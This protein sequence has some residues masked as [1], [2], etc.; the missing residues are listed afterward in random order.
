MGHRGSPWVTVGHR[1]SVWPKIYVKWIVKVNLHVLAYHKC[2]VEHFV[3]LLQRSVCSE[4]HQTA[5]NLKLQRIYTYTLQGQRI[6]HDSG[7]TCNAEGIIMY[8]SNSASGR[9]RFHSLQQDKEVAHESSTVLKALFGGHRSCRL[10]RLAAAVLE[11]ERPL[12][13]RS[14]GE[15][16]KILCKIPWQWQNDAKCLAS[17]LQTAALT[18]AFLRVSPGP[19]SVVALQFHCSTFNFAS[20]RQTWGQTHTSSNKMSYILY[21][22]VMSCFLDA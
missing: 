19:S 6:P 12:V 10:K 11:R 1:G 2:L 5:P 9:Q 17:F 18:G 4:N 21:H 15:L 8:M 3:G 13:E 22:F 7:V 20:E 16:L 14:Q